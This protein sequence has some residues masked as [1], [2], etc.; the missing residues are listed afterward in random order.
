MLNRF[1]T[2]FKPQSLADF[3]TAYY[4]QISDEQLFSYLKKDDAAA[5]EEI[6]NRY[7][8]L[9]IDA[10]YRPLHCREK[11]EDIVQEIFISLYQRRNA[12]EL[13]VSLKAYLL[14]ALK[15][16]ILNEIRSR[17]VRETYQKS[18]FF[19]PNCKNDF[20]HSC[21]TKELKAIIDRSVDQLPEKCKQAF[22]LS[23]KENLSYKEISGELHIS[24]ST[25][26]KHIS[27]ALKFLKCQLNVYL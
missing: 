26:E 17:I 5:F 16:K 19:D 22:L 13:E 21:E 10:A 20:A 11:A 1:C 4:Q 7:W 12:I 9:L 25:V 8:T 18:L 24:V 14:K 6:Y 3:M 27:K 15:F 23:R 2:I